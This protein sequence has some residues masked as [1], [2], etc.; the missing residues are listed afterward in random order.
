MKELTARQQKVLDFIRSHIVEKGYPP[1]LREIGKHMN[2]LSTNGVQDHLLA[3]E[4]KGFITRANLVSRG[5]RPVE[6]RTEDESVDRLEPFRNGI[7]Q[8]PA[9]WRAANA[10]LLADI[11]NVLTDE[12]VPAAKDDGEA[13]NLLQRVRIAAKAYKFR[14]DWDA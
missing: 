11:A 6:P 2:I 5:I 7:A 8:N 14:G 3:L 13:L 12:G 1:T 10:S 4:R 9:S